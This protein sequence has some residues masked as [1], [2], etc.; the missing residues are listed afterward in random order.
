MTKDRVD[1]APGDFRRSRR[2][3]APHLFALVGNDPDPPPSDL[4]PKKTWI[5]V[6]DLPTDVA[7]RTSSYDGSI[8]ARLADLHSGWIFSWPKIDEAPY[9]AEPALLAGEEF[10]ALVFNALHRYYRISFPVP[11]DRAVGGFGGAL[12]KHDI[13]S[14]M[15][16]R[17]VLRP[18][19]GNPQ[20]PAGAHTRDQ[21]PLERPAALNEQ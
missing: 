6:V 20:R 5:E 16:L 15:P 13:G 17:P 2:Y 8:I 12:G 4:I 11:R 18:R 3:L 21:L 9:M 10:D 19:S 1:L 7:L 14:D